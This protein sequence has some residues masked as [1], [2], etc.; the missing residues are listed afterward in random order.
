MPIPKMPSRK[1]IKIKGLQ[2][3]MKEG[4]KDID[5]RSYP[6][7]MKHEVLAHY[8]GGYVKG[9]SIGVDIAIDI[10]EKR[11]EYIVE[12]LNEVYIK[13]PEEK[14]DCY[15]SQYFC[16]FLQELQPPEQSPN[17]ELKQEMKGREL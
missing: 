10:A 1:E 14:T 15:C 13:M 7:G 17:E 6:R 12:R 5:C 16:S 4:E 2:G 11:I 8:Q 9:L 3:Q